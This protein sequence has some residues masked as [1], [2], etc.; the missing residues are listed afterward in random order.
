MYKGEE[1]EMTK[2]DLIKKLTSRKF[3]AMIIGLVSMLLVL[4]NVDANT[5]TQITAIIGSIASIIAYI[6]AEAYV[7]GQSA[8]N[9]TSNSVGTLITGVAE[10]KPITASENTDKP[11]TAD[12]A[13]ATTDTASTT[14]K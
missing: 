10:L 1:F 12:E 3:F 8:G 7:D 13:T 4:F 14:E 6:F 9:T 2:T 11:V 5:V